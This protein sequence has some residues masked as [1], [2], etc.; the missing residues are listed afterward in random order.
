MA[1]TLKAIKGQHLRLFVD[2]KVLAGART[3]SVQM[4]METEELNIKDVS[5]DWQAIVPT[6]MSWQ[7]SGTNVLLQEAVWGHLVGDVFDLV[8]RE[9]SL[10]FGTAAGEY[11]DELV[12]IALKGVGIITDLSQT[13]ANK[14][15]GTYSLTIE[16]C[17]TLYF[18]SAGLCDVDGVALFSSD[19][20]RLTAMVR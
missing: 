18:K 7:V 16:G 2:G 4:S 14:Q 3:C 11:N 19:G 5:D 17:G 12:A 13:A 10:T 15:L 6:G 9:V 1:S 8:G 20:K